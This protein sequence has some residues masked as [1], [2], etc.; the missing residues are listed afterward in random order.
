MRRLLVLGLFA[1][2]ISGCGT[3]TPAAIVASCPATAILAQAASVTKFKGPGARDAANIVLVADMDR[4]TLGCHYDPEDSEVDIDMQFPISVKR[5]MAGAGSQN[6]SYFVAV[7]DAAGNM[8]SKRTFDRA[9]D[10]SVGNEQTVTESVSGTNIKLGPDKRP[11]DYQIL[12]GFQLS[13]DE[14]AYNQTQRR[15]NP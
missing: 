14:L 13:A 6:L 12:V 5:G 4:P 10:V 11:Y 1:L 9:V 15:Y 7:V 8:L 3:D 2:P